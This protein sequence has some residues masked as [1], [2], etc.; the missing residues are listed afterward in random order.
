MNQEQTIDEQI[1]QRDEMIEQNLKIAREKEILRNSNTIN[2]F[3]ERFC[4]GVT[5]K[6]HGCYTPP[7]S[8]EEKVVFKQSSII[9]TNK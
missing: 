2:G 7:F 4:G 3:A 1:K 8:P 5:R 9:E 6:N